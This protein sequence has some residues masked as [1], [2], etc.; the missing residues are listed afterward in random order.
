MSEPRLLSSAFLLF[1]PVNESLLLK[2]RHSITDLDGEMAQGHHRE[3]HAKGRL[4]DAL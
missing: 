4:F 3:A 1:L 2:V